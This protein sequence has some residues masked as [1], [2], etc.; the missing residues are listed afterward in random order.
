MT[1][2]KFDKEKADRAVGFIEKYITHVKGEMGGQY[3]K[4]EKWQIDDIIYPV[5][6]TV[7]IKTGLRRYRTVYIE[8]PR[9][10]AKST[11][12][13]AIGLYLLLADGETGAEIYSAAADQKQASIIFD[14]AKNMVL[15]DDTLSRRCR[16]Y[17]YSISKRNSASFYKVIS[18]D[19]DTKHGFNAHGILFDELHTQKNR[20]LWDV[21]TTSTGSRRQPLTFAFT[22]AGY[23]KNSI[24]WEIHEYA[25]KVQEGIIVDDS[26]Y[27]VIYTTDMENDIYSP[28]TWEDANPGLGNIVKYEYISQAANKVKNNPSFENT[29]RR[30]HLNQWTES[31]TRWINDAIWMGCGEHAEPMGLCYGGLDLAS[32]RDITALVLLFPE[33]GTVEPYFFV[34]EITADD[35]LKDGVNYR[36]WINEGYIIETEGNVTDYNFV[37]AKIR[38][39]YD[40]YDIR[41]IAYDRW[42]ATQLVNDL[43]DEK[44]PMERFGQGYVSMNAPTKELEKR[45][46]NKEIKHGG[47]PVLRWMCS[48]VMIKED[49]AGNIKIDKGKSTEK[50]DGM[51]ALV[52]ALGEA[53]TDDRPIG[54]VYDER[55]VVVI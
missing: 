23:D 16:P 25:R 35:R 43:I 48:N 44:I 17:L 5:F 22:T 32:T 40:K 14:I 29:F 52:M 28:V 27:S 2:Y 11:L 33:T 18:A 49:P 31:E 37:K 34:P 13:A 53:M 1:E 4:L 7:N 30:L 36:Q 6:G 20:D 41:S 10:N 26:F 54:S 8:I 9:K 12:G 38:E 21:L 55:G 42:N 3:I 24:C 45:V 19:A 46:L 15:Q 51:V 50:V 39:L 47:N